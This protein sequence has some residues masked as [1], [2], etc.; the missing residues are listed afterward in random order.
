[1][2]ASFTVLT[3]QVAA[4]VDTLAKEKATN[5]L[6]IYVAA[7]P[8]MASATPNAVVSY[9]IAGRSITRKNDSEFAAYVASVESQI[10][11]LIY[12]RTSYID[13]S[14]ESLR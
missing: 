6:E 4:I 1:M 12:G 5:L 9:T 14:S 11:E 8:A 3:A 13:G 10:Y 7:W 2:A